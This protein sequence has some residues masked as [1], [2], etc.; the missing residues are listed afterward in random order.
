MVEAWL[1]EIVKGIGKLFLHP[2]LYWGIILVFVTGILRIK[3][4]RRQ[5]GYKVFHMFSELKNTWLFSLVTGLVL[6]IICLTIGIVLSYEVIFLISIVTVLLSLHFR[7]SLLSASYIL[8]ITY[9]IV[10]FA[11]TMLNEQNGLDPTLFSD[12]SLTGLSILLSLFLVVEALLLFRVRRNETFPGLSLSNRGEWI[13]QHNIK[14]LAVIPFFIPVPTGLITPFAA[15]W[16]LF[17]IEGETY[18][19]LLFPFLIGIDYMSKR[20]LPTAVAKEIAQKTVYL[21]IFVLVLATFSIIISWFSLLSVLVGIIGKEFIHYQHREQ[22]KKKSSYFHRGLKVL[23]I[24]PGTPA[25]RLGILVGETIV[26]VNGHKIRT[27]DE[28]YEKLRV[29]G[30]FFK[31]DLL[32]VDGEIRFLQSPRYEGD[33]YKLGIIFTDN[34][35]KQQIRS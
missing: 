21:A 13:G 11:P 18:S 35:Y 27:P 15:Y 19:L 17:S 4:E 25:E 9:L 28:F 14:K 8:G 20:Q 6:S 31:L 1:V 7:F 29:S 5:F 10:L 16:P 2:L 22:E 30:S 23:G 34:P 24:I 26:K 12:V 32:D 3:R 33:H